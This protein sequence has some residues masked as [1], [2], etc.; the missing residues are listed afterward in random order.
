MIKRLL[1]KD[2]AILRELE[3]PLKA[4][5]TVITGETGAGKSILVKALGLALGGKALKTD[6][7][8]GQDRAVVEIEEQSGNQTVVLRRV[9]SRNGRTRSFI[10]DEPI[11]EAQYRHRTKPFADFHGQHEQQY[12]MDSN[13]HIDF[14]DS[15]CGQETRVDQIKDCFQTM[16]EKQKTLNIL[17]EKQE[18]VSNQRALLEFQIQ[19][20]DAVN[21]SG[22]EDIA[23]GQ[24][25]KTLSHV[26][27]LIE[28][29]HGMKQSL[30]EN[31]QSVYQQL[32]AA[33]QE[34]ERL[35]RFDE[36]LRPMKELLDQ[37]AIAIQD[38]GAALIQ[39]VDT[40]DHNP[41]RL[42]EIED[43][44]GA[45]ESLKRKYGGSLAAVLKYKQQAEKEYS[46]LEH[47]DE[48]IKH[49]EKELARLTNEYQQLALDLHRK[50]VKSAN[51][52]EA[53]IEQEMVKLDM[54]DATFQVNLAVEK[55]NNSTLEI[56]G[57]R[58][59]VGPK[60]F[61]QVVFLLS[62]N[63]GEEPKPLQ[64]IASGGEISRIMLA[65]KSVL[66]ADDPVETLIFDE[67]DSGISGQAAEK[68]ADSLHRL[69]EQKQVICITHLPQIASHA[70]HHLYVQK[71]V[72][73]QQTEVCFKYLSPPE[74][75]EA[76][77]E[78]FSGAVV[79]NETLSSAR[80]FLELARG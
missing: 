43:R 1:I 47:I 27:E 18:N 14:L 79:T 36:S 24:E 17:R 63:P 50:R 69:A 71:R 22:K 41:A 29:I 61:D 73:G 9:V 12:I 16:V 30:V 77:A 15:Y 70:D 65:I 54:P 74:K 66:Q 68:V 51:L 57:Q 2:Y 23:L 52:L 11:P 6:L 55:D 53:A 56:E 34:L 76:I 45:I 38:A 25:F 72:S 21:P 37:A 5:L 64:Y 49:L 80:K 48:E 28:T 10:N 20:I 44:L 62:A 40:L 58:L 32:S 33:I 67:I 31:D 8:S 59:K 7:R 60:G 75:V 26:D 13:T 46:Q 39:H 78:L 3:L 42:R 35:G 4:G 19:E